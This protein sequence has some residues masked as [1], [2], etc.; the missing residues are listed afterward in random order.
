MDDSGSDDEDADD[1]ED[2]EAVEDSSSLN[3]SSM[4]ADA[5]LI[6]ECAT[7]D[8]ASGMPHRVVAAP[9]SNTTA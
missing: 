8:L 2:E 6:M 4:S 1:E 9:T 7:S 5:D 3:S